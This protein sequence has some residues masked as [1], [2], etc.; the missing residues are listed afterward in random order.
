MLQP[1]VPH[2]R[3]LST[4]HVVLVATL[5]GQVLVTDTAMSKKQAMSNK[6]PA[7]IHW[8]QTPHCSTFF[9][10]SI[11]VC[12][13][14]TVCACHD[15]PSSLSTTT[16]IATTTA[17]AAAIGSTH[18]SRAIKPECRAVAGVAVVLPLPQR[19]RLL[20]PLDKARD[21]HPK[22]QP[23]ERLPWCIRQHVVLQLQL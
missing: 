8:Q 12:A 19:P 14:Y 18:P 1:L 15:T 10:D 21:V 13:D 23:V 4:W 3:V 9:I 22:L 5:A 7:A 6:Q 20:C 17:V 16:T 11:R 2:S